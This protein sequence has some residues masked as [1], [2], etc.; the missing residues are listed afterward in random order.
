[1]IHG[2]YVNLPCLFHAEYLICFSVPLPS[3]IPIGL[4]IHRATAAVALPHNIKQHIEPYSSD[5]EL[6]NAMIEESGFKFIE[7]FGVL[8]YDRTS[9]LM[10]VNEILPTYT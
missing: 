1:M 2:Q 6:E 3:T 4:F 9:P 8:L 7:H 5:A 10:T